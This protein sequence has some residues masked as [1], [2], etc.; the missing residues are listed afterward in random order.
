[1]HSSSSTTKHPCRR[2]DS[3]AQSPYPGRARSRANNHASV[4]VTVAAATTEQNYTDTHRDS[5]LAAEALELLA[6]APD[7]TLRAQV[8]NRLS[9]V[10]RKQHALAASATSDIATNLHTNLGNAHGQSGG[11]HQAMEH[12]AEARPPLSQWSLRESVNSV[13]SPAKSL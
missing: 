1:M 12:Y 13:G 10:Q 9:L 11:F 8:L 5:R 2:A 7:D 6:T 3:G 4:P